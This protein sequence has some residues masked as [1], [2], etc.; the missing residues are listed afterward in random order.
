MK[1]LKRLGA[2]L[3]L[4]FVLSLS[5]F[6]G[7]I[8]SPPCAPPGEVNAPPCVAAPLSLDDST[9]PGQ[10]ETPPAS[11]AVDILSVVDAAINLLL[12]F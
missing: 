5:A 7:E 10:T 4:T 8:N 11:D 12:L 6:A 1:N 2:T 3:V 9:A